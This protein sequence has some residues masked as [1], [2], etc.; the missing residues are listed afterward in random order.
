M[1][2]GKQRQSVGDLMTIQ[3]VAQA[4]GLTYWQVDRLI[5]T[6]KVETIKVGNTR[7]V[8]LSDVELAAR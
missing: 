2:R 3:G 4:L 1:E 8:R 5:R 7:L 6:G